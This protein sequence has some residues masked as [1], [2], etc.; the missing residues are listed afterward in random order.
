MGGKDKFSVVATT[1]GI[2]FGC[3]AE[4][5]L[6]QRCCSDTKSGEEAA[7]RF[8]ICSQGTGYVSRVLV[9]G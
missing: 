7:W 3:T 6:C 4:A 5:C 9:H 8:G 2:T 1:D